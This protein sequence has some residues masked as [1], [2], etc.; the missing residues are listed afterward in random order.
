MVNNSHEKKITLKREMRP[1]PSLYA[2][3]RFVNKCFSNCNVIFKVTI[4]K[5]LPQ[6][7][8]NKLR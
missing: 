5:T 4:L 8:E 2:S 6:Q 3:L 1:Y 7:T